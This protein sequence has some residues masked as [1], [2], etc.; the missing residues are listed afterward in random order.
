MKYLPAIIL[1]WVSFIFGGLVANFILF[2]ILRESGIQEGLSGILS[3]TVTIIII[4]IL[5]R[6]INKSIT[7]QMETTKCQQCNNNIP[8]FPSLLHPKFCSSCWANRRK[9]IKLLGQHGIT[10]I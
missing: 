7:K 5:N 4:V 1:K 3:M 10:P 8:F 6:S 2:A 9:A